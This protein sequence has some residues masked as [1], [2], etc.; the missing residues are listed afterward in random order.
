VTTRAGRDPSPLTR[1]DQRNQR[2]AGASIADPD[3]RTG[4]MIIGVL[5]I[6][7]AIATGVGLVLGE[8]LVAGVAAV[9][10]LVFLTVAIF[11]RHQVRRRRAGTE[12]H[13]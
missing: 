4:V 2:W 6:V 12:R 10:S 8:A 11:V 1:W 3:R 9:K 7:Y 13:R 5:G